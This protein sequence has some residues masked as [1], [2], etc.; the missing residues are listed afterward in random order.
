MGVIKRQGIK[1]TISGYLGILMGFV[2]LIIIQPHFLTKEEL[3]LTRIL[4]SFSVLV[5]MFVPLGIG[6]AT[7]KYFPLFRDAQRKHH[8][9]FGFMLLFPLIGFL[10]AWIL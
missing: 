7:V 3:G 8:G 10:L 6:N 1:N 9:Y 4:Y 2:N 5:A